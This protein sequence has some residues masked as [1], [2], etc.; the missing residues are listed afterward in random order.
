[1][2]LATQADV[3]AELRRDLTVDE[4]SGVAT[5]LDKASDLVL[6]YLRQT[7]PTPTPGP[8]VRVVAEMVAAV[9]SR[10]ADTP[11][12]VTTQGAGPFSSGFVA[13]STSRGPW[14]TAA[15]KIRLRPWR[16]SMVA[17]PMVGEGYA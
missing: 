17:T 14:L 3:E 6:G 9:F 16:I 10:S 11:Q 2:A 1:M 7:P 12:D 15:Q 5:E 8:I 13:G 4:E